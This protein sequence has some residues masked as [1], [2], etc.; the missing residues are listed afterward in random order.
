MEKDRGIIT[1][2]DKQ[3]QCDIHV[4]MQKKFTKYF[5]L[6]KK[7]TT[8]IDVGHKIGIRYILKGNDYFKLFFHNFAVEVYY[9]SKFYDLRKWL[10]ICWNLAG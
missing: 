4:V 5:K 1:N 2:L 10:D 6:Y 3:K 9:F 7:D 8:F